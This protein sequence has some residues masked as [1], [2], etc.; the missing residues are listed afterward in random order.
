MKNKSKSKVTLKDIA[1]DTGLSISTVSRALA[2]SGKISAENEKKIFESAK[3]LN[4]PVKKLDTPLDL[5]KNIF[6][7][8]ITRFHI[9]EFYSSFYNGFDMA[10]KDTNTNI[11]LLNVSNASVDEITL[12]DELHKTNFD[13]AIV[14][15]P[16]F[17]QDDYKQLIERTD[18]KFPIISVAPIANPVMDTITFD[19]YRGGHLVADHFYKQG[20]KKLGIINGP[21]NKSEAMLRRNGFMDF[22]Q[23]NSELELVWQ[24][25]GNFE[26]K[27]GHK[28]FHYYDDAKDKPEA[29]FCGNDSMAVGFMQ[30]ALHEGVNI[31]GDVA[32][33]GY[34][35][36]P[37]CA[38]NSPTITSV[39]TPFEMLGK[40]A[41]KYLIERLKNSSS[42][43][44]HAGYVSLVPVSLSVRESSSNADHLVS[45]KEATI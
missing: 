44:E 29:I 2:R 9:G 39:H 35:D 3:R 8:L 10:T 14:F 45:E 7:A 22:I 20:F 12:I 40:K 16:D 6:I 32:I 31:P 37:V 1:R 42:G 33:A 17:D 38:Y 28:A 23:S 30:S 25:G 27:S 43:N 36:L 15:L 19:T 41:I 26:N 24:Y 11:A 13:A 18:S 4:Y 21:Q 5:R 34:D